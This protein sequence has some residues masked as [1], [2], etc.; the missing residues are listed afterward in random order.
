MKI[1]SLNIYTPI[2]PGQN[3]YNKP[4]SNLGGSFTLQKDSFTKASNTIAFKGT[5]QRFAEAIKEMSKELK[6]CIFDQEFDFKAVKAVVSKYVPG[7]DIGIFN[8]HANQIVTKAGDIGYLKVPMSFTPD[9]KVVLQGRE[10]LITPPR[11]KSFAEKVRVYKNIVH[12]STH[13]G[14]YD[15]KEKSR[16]EVIKNFLKGRNLQN[17]ETVNSLKMS[18]NLF[19][20]IE[21]DI[22]GPLLSAL[23]KENNMPTQI[24][25]ASDKTL[26]SLFAPIAK[27]D[28]DTYMKKIIQNYLSQVEK[29]GQI[30]RKFVLN[31]IEIC[32]KNESEAYNFDAQAAKTALNI[33]SDTDFDLIP[34]LYNRL[35]KIAQEMSS[36]S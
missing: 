1:N 21:S 16:L 8:P 13:A 5:Q 23:R 30:N 18:N 6:P 15:V 22:L 29:M 17:S 11:D 7:I 19:K 31:F 12:E 2:T 34:L 20:A 32:A 28:I 10:L 14:Q 35:S 25:E 27:S 3:S 36:K 26:E 4:S 9:G 33:Q 24:P